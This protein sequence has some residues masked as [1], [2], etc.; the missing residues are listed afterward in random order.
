G[1][2]AHNVVFYAPWLPQR[3]MMK[4]DYVRH[5]SDKL[6]YTIFSFPIET[7]EKDID[8][9]ER[10]YYYPESGWPNMVFTAQEK[11]TKEYNLQPRKLLIM[12]I[13]AGSTMAANI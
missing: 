8:N 7:D 2:N 4:Q 5:F 10:C 11:L 9:R 12:G 1:P 6:G 3:N 13:S